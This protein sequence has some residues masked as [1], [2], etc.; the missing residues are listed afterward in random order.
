MEVPLALEDVRLVIPY[1]ITTK[2]GDGN[3]VD[4]WTDVAVDNIYMER[5]TT[6]VDPFTKVDY[7]TREFPEEHRFDPETGLPIFDRYIAGT[8]RRIQWPWETI[9]PEE[10]TTKASAT[11]PKQSLIGKLKSPV[12]T[13]KKAFSR[14]NSEAQVGVPVLTEEDKAA[15][16]TQAVLEQ[17]EKT[18]ELP[19][20]PPSGSPADHEDDTGRNKAEPSP[21]TSS[22]YPTLVYPPFPEQLTSEIKTHAKEVKAAERNEKQDWYENPKE[23]SLEERATRKAAKAEK[24]R[25]KGVPEVMKTPLQLRW[26]MERV[27]QAEQK[28]NMKVDRKVLMM[29]LGAHIEGQ[30]VSRSP[31]K[32]ET[33]VD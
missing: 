15:Q 5:H 33:E 24:L 1:R 11:E 28:A 27:K 19:R 4:T 25:R 6:G 20:G 26:E 21:N 22:F 23:V 18:P 29:A 17:V 9:V 16:R 30:Q 2:D 31:Q 13:L 32:A 14:E 7:G 12:K 8:R 10:E 3:D